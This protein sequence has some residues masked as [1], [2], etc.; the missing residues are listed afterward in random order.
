MLFLC[1]TKCAWRPSHRAEVLRNKLSCFGEA[2]FWLRQFSC[3]TT[4]RSNLKFS[5]MYW[6]DWNCARNV[7][8]KR[9]RLLCSLSVCE[10]NFCPKSCDELQAWR[11]RSYLQR[12]KL[13]KVVFQL[14]CELWKGICSCTFSQSTLHRRERRLER[15]EYLW[16]WRVIWERGRQCGIAAKISRN[17][18]RGSL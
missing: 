5:A 10:N 6:K 9:S 13:K 16:E 8:W 4:Q 18:G 7:K 2:F 1:D 15:A 17:V 14:Q 12:R 3:N 11:V